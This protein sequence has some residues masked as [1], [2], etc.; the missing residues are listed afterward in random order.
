MRFFFGVH[1]YVIRLFE[2]DDISVSIL[3]IR[4]K[5]FSAKA[6]VDIEL[7]ERTAYR[8]PVGSDP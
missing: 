1:V 6:G 5:Y 2:A 3:D 4:E 7:T 8:Q